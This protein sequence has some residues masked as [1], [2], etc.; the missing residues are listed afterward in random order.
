VKQEALLM[1]RD[2][3]TRYVSKFVLFHK[4]IQGRWQWCHSIG[5]IQCPISVP[6]QLCLSFTVNEMLSLVFPNLQRLRDTSF[7]PFG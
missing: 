5:H 3:A 4:V 1:Q 6:L 2:H 7:I